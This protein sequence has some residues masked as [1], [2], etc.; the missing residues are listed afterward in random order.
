VAEELLA[1]EDWLAGWRDG[2]LPFA[3][4]ER[5]W[6]DPGEAGDAAA[7]DGRLALRLPARRAFGTGSHASTRLAV[8]WLEEIPMAGRD[9]LDVGAGSGILAFVCLSLGAR[10]AIGVER[11]LESVLL[12]GANRRRNRLAVGLVGGTVAALG[13]HRFQVIAANLLSAHLAPELAA[14]AAR[15]EPGGD[16]VYSGALSIERRDLV[17]RFREHGLEPLGEKVDGEWSA[18]RLR[19]ERGS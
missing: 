15:L 13:E 17:A 9:A 6:V 2:A 12:A 16:L 8:S 4:G 5:F 7:P 18:F 10:R 3:L 11:E 19:R 1:D 14:L